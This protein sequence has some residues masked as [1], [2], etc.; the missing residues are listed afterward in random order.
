MQE[1]SER[2][3]FKNRAPM[4]FVS[5][6]TIKQPS[7]SSFVKQLGQSKKYKKYCITHQQ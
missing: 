1:W 6:N 5:Q 2:I 4:I 7:L 3:G